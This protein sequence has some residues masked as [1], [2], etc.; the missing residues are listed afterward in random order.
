MP[1]DKS[2]HVKVAVRVRPILP[3]DKQPDVVVLP[4]RE[5][6]RGCITVLDPKKAFA[7]RKEEIDY[8]RADYVRERQ[9]DF[10][11]VYGP[12]DST[13]SVYKESVSPLVDAV[14][15]GINVTIF[16]YGQTGS[17]KTHT[18][19]GH[20]GETGVMRL[21]LEQLFAI[22]SETKTKFMVSFVELYNEEIRD[23]LGDGPIRAKADHGGCGG[24]ELRE[25][26]KLGP[27]I[28][29]VTEVHVA[30]VDAV[31]ELL[32]QGNSRRTQESTGAHAE[33][34]RSHAILQINVEATDVLPPIRRSS[35]SQ[36]HADAQRGER[37]RR[38]AKLCMIDLAGSERAA[39][40]QNSGARLAEGARINRSLLALGNVINGLRRAHG[41]KG[42]GKG[43]AAY[44][45]FRDSKL[46][47]LLKDSLGGNT[48]TLML[49]H[50]SPAASSFE[51][52][53]NTLKYAH[54]ARAIKNTV[55]ENVRKVD[56]PKFA[57]VA[58]LEQ[59][60]EQKARRDKRA[61]DR[62]KQKRPSKV[63]PD[64]GEKRVRKN[65][66]EGTLQPCKSEGSTKASESQDKFSKLK[67]RLR[68]RK[69]KADAEEPRPADALQQTRRKVIGQLREAIELRQTVFEMTRGSRV[70]ADK[71]VSG[72]IQ[73]DDDL[74]RRDPLAFLSNALMKQTTAPAS[75]GKAS[76]NKSPG[77]ADDEARESRPSGDARPSNQDDSPGSIDA[78]EA[79]EARV[80]QRAMKECQG[81]RRAVKR[82]LEKQQAILAS[83][84]SNESPARGDHKGRL[85]RL[86]DASKDEQNALLDAE[87]RIVGL[88]L[89]K[90]EVDAAKHEDHRRGPE[91]ADDGDVHEAA[92]KKLE[93]QVRLRNSVI[94]KLVHELERRADAPEQRPRDKRPS[95]ADVDG[96]A[97]S[98][99]RA[100][101]SE[102]FAEILGSDAFLANLPR[103][104]EPQRPRSARHEK[105]PDVRWR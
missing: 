62:A 16:A 60:L 96:F 26:P 41:D 84:G 17:G 61:S 81:L 22:S 6:G 66:S 105:S 63:A 43:A 52:T 76:P 20:R 56:K 32:H 30:N 15:E 95:S 18:M 42:P 24:L 9:Y 12:E 78:R 73:T 87:M 4:S 100:P 74:L 40:T 47:R 104:A 31:M 39:E 77:K 13:E 67:S 101:A 69:S 19:L 85:L 90:L 37:V 86:L 44:V 97:A 27:T 68:R 57:K 99:R 55:R 98:P 36:Q 1:K 91:S 10:D 34:S 2:F 75:K 51:E 3:H 93:L 49:A 89:E 80:Q 21:T 48:R 83:I 38:R 103:H 23:L 94:R 33:S 8:L 35:A 53:L 54:R 5:A 70:E 50:A 88:E 7:G 79:R 64:E 25:D 28:C 92:L 46:T 72:R 59:L 65:S 82:N 71:L 11:H 29:G 58:P 102:L 45:N 14:M